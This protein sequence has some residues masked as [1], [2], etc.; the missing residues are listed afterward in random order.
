M[1]Y[2]FL[3]E[4][5]GTKLFIA[6]L[7]IPSVISP[8]VAGSMW[9][10]MFDN[11]FGPVNQ[12][13][14]L[15][16]SEPITILWTQQP[17]LAYIAIIIA[18]VWEWT[19]FMFIILLAG[20]SNVDRDQ[21]DAAAID[22]AGRW[23]VFRHIALPS[24]W[25]VMTIALLIRGLDLFRMFDVVWQMT[26]GGPGTAT[27]TI[28]IYM[29]IRGFEQFETSYVAAQVV[30]LLILVTLLVMMLLRRLKVAR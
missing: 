28:S 4:R 16:F 15:P 7:I 29:Y 23:N 8:I 3:E 13:I 14:G 21:L 18:E 5:I 2:H 17:I 6:L 20:L 27:E 22:G 9:R 25:P 24:I 26:R 10:L 30:L 11:R 12:I 19:P 1:A